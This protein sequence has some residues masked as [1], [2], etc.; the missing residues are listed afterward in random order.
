MTTDYDQVSAKYDGRYLRHSYPGLTAT[1]QAFVGERPQRVLELG[2][3]TGHWIEMLLAGGHDARGI[4]PSTG[5]LDKARSKV[6][7]DRLSHARA[8][9]LPFPDASFDRVFAMNAVHHFSDP[10]RALREA[11]RVL[12]PGGALMVCGLDPSIGVASWAVYDF[13]PGTRARDLERYPSMITV[14][15]W[16]ADAGFVQLAV[17]E[18]EHIVQVREARDALATGA[19]DK[20]VTSQ[21]SELSDERYQH[22][23][24]AIM[25]AAAE[26]EARQE[27]LRLRTDLTLHAATG[28]KPL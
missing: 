6:P 8:E 14:R 7:P 12:V 5:M 3:G 17:H 19:L 23:I 11:F 26:A 25:A 10:Q 15:A 13:F 16:L 22:G 4:D 9:A 18:A 28:C 27:V 2:A 20:A 21:L 1:L 24:A